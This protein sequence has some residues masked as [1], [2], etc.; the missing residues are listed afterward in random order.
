MVVSSTE[1]NP[2]CL[3]EMLHIGPVEQIGEERGP[4]EER[5]IIR[6]CWESIY[7]QFIS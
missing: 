1:F 5:A 7:T 2:D 3:N 4:N 6:W